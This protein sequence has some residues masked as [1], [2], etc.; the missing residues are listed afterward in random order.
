MLLHDVNIGIFGAGHLARALASQLV[1]GGIADDNLSVCHRGSLATRRALEKA[2]LAHLI[3]KPADL[4]EWS[5]IL[6]YTV[7]PQDYKVIAKHN[8]PKELLFVS[9]LAGVPLERIPVGVPQDQRVRIMP[10][11]PDTLTHGRAIAAVYPA[12]NPEIRALLKLI[13]ARL[14]SLHRESDM[15]AFTALGPCLPMAL[16]FWES[17]GKTVEEREILDIAERFGLPD[18]V[19]LLKWAREAQP[20]GLS[21]N[22]LDYYLSQ[23]A[24]EGG[25]TEAILLAIREGKPF[26]DSLCSGIERSVELS[27]QD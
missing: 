1:R 26:P 20:R 13:G 18:P 19:G 23:A 17:L 14:Y 2:G 8:T 21:N 16:A 3:R 4:L 9:L 7:R 12:A 6:L 27:K 25:V 22:E 11:A 5:N 24:T 15:H 10:S